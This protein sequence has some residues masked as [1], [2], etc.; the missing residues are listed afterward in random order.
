MRD[1]IGIYSTP[2]VPCVLVHVEIVVPLLVFP[3]N[4]V[5]PPYR[6]VY[7]GGWRPVLIVLSK[8]VE[9]SALLTG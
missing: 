3:V 8:R 2:A 5:S 6:I 7:F 9:A 1:I 4:V